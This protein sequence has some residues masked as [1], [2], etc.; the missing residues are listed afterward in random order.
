MS[1]SVSAKTRLVV[2]GPGAGSKLTKAEAL[3]IEVW[4]EQQ[5]LDYLQA[6]EALVP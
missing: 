4:D 6:H 2:A 5:L 3:G 1:G